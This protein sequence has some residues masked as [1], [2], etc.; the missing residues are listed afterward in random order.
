MKR[1]MIL[2]LATRR[3]ARSYLEGS[4]PLFLHRLSRMLRKRRKSISSDQMRQAFLKPLPK[5]TPRYHLLIQ[6]E[7]AEAERIKA[8]RLASYN[9][10]KANKPK[11]AAKVCAPYSYSM[12]QF[13]I[14][15]PPV[16]SYS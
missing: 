2:S 12:D 10:K 4:G 7:D 8:E 11:A 14:F 6:E 16:G 3:L 15:Y 13:M 1:S 9:A 5:L